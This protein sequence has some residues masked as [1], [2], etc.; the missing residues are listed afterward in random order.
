MDATIVLAKQDMAVIFQVMSDFQ[1][2]RILES[3]FQ[4]RHRISKGNLV[5][6]PG[7]GIKV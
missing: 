1:N 4:D 7:I 3:G 6:H 5:R 2:R